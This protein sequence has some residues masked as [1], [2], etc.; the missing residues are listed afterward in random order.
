MMALRIFVLPL[1]GGPTRMTAEADLIAVRIMRSVRGA[2]LS[3][4]VVETVATV[5]ADPVA[6]VCPAAV[7]GLGGARSAG[8]E[9]GSQG[10]AAM[11]SS[12]PSAAPEQMVESSSS[13]RPNVALN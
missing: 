13:V 3:G 9:A 1:P 8:M 4:M 6:P 5:G 2:I 12:C 7:A 11:G 10:G